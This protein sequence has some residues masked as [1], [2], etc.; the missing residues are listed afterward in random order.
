MVDAGSSEPEVHWAVTSV[1]VIGPRGGSFDPGV[2]S[3]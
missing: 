3:Q 1:I 2:E